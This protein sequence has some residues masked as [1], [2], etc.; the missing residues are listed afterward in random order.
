MNRRVVAL[1]EASLKGWRGR[2]ARPVASAVSA[3]TNASEQ[4]VRAII[5]LAFLALS[6]YLLASTIRRGLRYE[7]LNP[8]D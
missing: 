7:A 6:I 4:D 2:V 5:G 3:R 1:G 8:A